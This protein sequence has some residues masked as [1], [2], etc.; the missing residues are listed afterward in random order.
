MSCAQRARRARDR[1]ARVQVQFRIDI[2]LT[3]EQAFP[4]TW[5]PRSENP[6]GNLKLPLFIDSRRLTA[7]Q[8]KAADQTTQKL[9]S[10]PN[11]LS[12]SKREENGDAA[13]S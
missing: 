9:V 3:M 6:E 10:D 12:R 7:A 2:N 4:E 5:P 13:R 1:V 11:A 8:E